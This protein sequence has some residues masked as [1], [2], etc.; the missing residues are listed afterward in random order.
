MTFFFCFLFLH[1]AI[2]SFRSQELNSLF[3]KEG[4]AGFLDAKPSFASP[5]SIDRHTHHTMVVAATLGWESTKHMHIFTYYG[6]FCLHTLWVGFPFMLNLGQMAVR[7]VGGFCTKPR[8]CTYVLTTQRDDHVS[9]MLYT[10]GHLHINTSKEA[11]LTNSLLPSLPP[12][13]SFF[14]A[15]TWRESLLY[16]K[17]LCP[18]HVAKWRRLANFESLGVAKYQSFASFAI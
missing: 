14:Q 18:C 7:R 10:Y 2:A 4:K 12:F 16:W 3:G 11:N 17:E 5:N 13:F 6:R 8:L 1:P 9:S 15:R